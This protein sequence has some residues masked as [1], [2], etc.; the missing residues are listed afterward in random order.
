MLDADQLRVLK[1][2]IDV[3]SKQDLLNLNTLRNEVKI[4]ERP[5]QIRDYSTT[6][7]RSCLKN[8]KGCAI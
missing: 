4:I 3:A 1:A 7:I 2:E 6:A 8:G 5:R